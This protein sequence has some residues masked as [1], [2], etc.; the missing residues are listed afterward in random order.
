MTLAEVLQ[1]YT[2][3]A[4]L[5]VLAFLMGTQH[6]RI[7]QLEVVAKELRAADGKADGEGNGIIDRLA[8]LE[9]NSDNQGKQLDK[10]EREM[11][12]VQRQLANLMRGGN[13]PIHEFVPA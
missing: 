5:V 12:G 10:I 6:Q 8:R 9:T 11:Q 1:L 3:L 2:P 4:G 7:A 13:G